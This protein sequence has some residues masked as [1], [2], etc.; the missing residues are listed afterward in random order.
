MNDEPK[1]NPVHSMAVSMATMWGLPESDWYHFVDSVRT[2]LGLIQ[3]RAY[4]EGRVDGLLGH[5]NECVEKAK[6]IDAEAA[7]VDEVRETENVTIPVGPPR[8]PK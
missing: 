5:L 1:N 2:A 7:H 6:K 3:A 4:A 8:A